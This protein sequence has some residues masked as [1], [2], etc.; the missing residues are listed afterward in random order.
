LVQHLK[1]SIVEGCVGAWVGP[2]APAGKFPWGDET[3]I[4]VNLHSSFERRG[5]GLELKSLSSQK[6]TIIIK[7]KISL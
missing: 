4:F 5:R 3:N 7:L 2:W 1:N 6:D